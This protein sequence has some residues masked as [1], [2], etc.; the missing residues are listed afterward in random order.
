[1]RRGSTPAATPMPA[2]HPDAG[3][4]REQLR[5]AITALAGSD[6]FMDI[7]AEE[8]SSAGLLA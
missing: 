6:A 7:I 8:L 1:M 5:K 4:K 3:A 2:A